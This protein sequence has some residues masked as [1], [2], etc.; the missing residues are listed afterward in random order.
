MLSQVLILC[1]VWGWEKVSD[2]MAPV[3]N[4]LQPVPRGDSPWGFRL[5]ASA[6]W[7]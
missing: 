7:L 5:S 3:T 4:T 2:T 1:M 6:T